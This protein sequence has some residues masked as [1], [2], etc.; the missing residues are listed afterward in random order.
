LFGGLAGHKAA[1]PICGL[2][3]G[4]DSQNCF[5]IVAGKQTTA[6]GS[7][8]LAHN[9]D[10]RGRLL[11]NVYK[12]PAQEHHRGDTVPINNAVTLPQLKNTP[13]LLWLEIPETEFAD[14][15][16]NEYGVVV[17][18]NACPS[19]ED[20]PELS[21]GGIGFMLRRLIAERAQTARDGV[22]IAGEL[23]AQFGY[24]SS[25][26]TYSIADE[27]E[28]WLLHAVHGKHWVARR[29]P[30]HEVAVIAN[31]Y[32]IGPVDLADR[33]QCLG[34]PDIIDYAEQRGW[35]NPE[36]DGTFDF[37]RAYS[38]PNDRTD[39]RNVLR[40][41]QGIN[42]LA[43]KA[44]KVEERLPF[45]FKPRRA[46]RLADLFQVL[47]DHYEGTKYDLSDH[48]KNGSPN[49]GKNRTICT[50]STQYSLV[51]QMR[52]WLPAEIAHVVWISFRR[53]DSNAYSPWYAAGRQ[54]P[55]GYSLSGSA[56]ALK[57]HF[58]PLADPVFEDPNLAFNTFARLS[59][60]VDKQ[61]KA[62]IEKTLKLWRNHEDWLFKNLKDHENEFIHL[63]KNNKNV[64]RKIIDNYTHSLEYRRWFLALELLREFR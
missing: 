36:K 32:T 26:R 11:V 30:D 19:R 34:S 45:S 39:M 16:V 24:N 64:A 43:A 14:T 37:A 53:P 20:K 3:A 49:S 44:S 12:I 27:N 58:T 31:C 48:Y 6:D 21:K 62:R 35:Y 63:L 29:V 9:E 59:E 22:R 7:V 18:S 10:D 40:Q 38:D 51:A 54:I 55:D 60:M 28:G 4:A 17:V 47:R 61:Y 13:G 15:Y 8:L 23:I 41:W 42:L 50:E 1:V 52:D 57:D 33:N 5:T 2:Q 56:S 46:I 25:G